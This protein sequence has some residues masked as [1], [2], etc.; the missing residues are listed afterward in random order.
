MEYVVTKGLEYDF[1]Q[2]GNYNE[3]ENVYRCFAYKVYSNNAVRMAQGYTSSCS[4]FNSELSLDSAYR[5]SRSSSLLLWDK[6][7]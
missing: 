5:F 2:E 6:S 1:W 7:T 4:G 3:D